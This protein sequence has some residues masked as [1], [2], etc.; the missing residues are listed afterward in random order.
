[1]CIFSSGFAE[2]S[3]RAR[4]QELHVMLLE[5]KGTD[6]FESCDRDKGCLSDRRNQLPQHQKQRHKRYQRADSIDQ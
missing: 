4:T 2:Y 3:Y 5:G 1:M 6:V